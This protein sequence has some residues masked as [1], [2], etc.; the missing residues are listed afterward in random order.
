MVH[1]QRYRR[2]RKTVYV[3][4][5]GNAV[6]G[7]FKLIVGLIGNSS[8][9]VADSLHSI[10]DSLTSVIVW[11]GMKVGT[12]R[13]D[14]EHS[15]GH[16]DAE[17]IAGLFVSI[18]LIFLGFEFAMHSYGKLW[19]PVL[20]PSV[21]TLFAALSSIILKYWMFLYARRVGE[22]IHSSAVVADAY[23][24]KSDYM[25]SVIVL[26]AIAGSIMGYPILD[27]IA[28]IIVSAWIVW[29]GIN[30]CL[31]NIKCLMG[32]VPKEMR[33]EIADAVSS[34][35]GVREFHRLR[36]HRTGPDI[37]ITLHIAIDK[38]KSFRQAHEI[39]KEVE[40]KIK[41]L[42]KNCNVVVHADPE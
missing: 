4:L 3:S 34:V 31:S 25:T 19:A 17:S 9:L 6:L 28:G 16:G 37:S 21:L 36:V 22:E 30:V 39:T 35:K 42:V 2:A 26:F 7:A 38:N 41:S 23:H 14:A 15:Y 24:H 11:V 20:V 5:A 1:E 18:F 33:R 29:I 10:S 32:G 27:P 12:K 13:P 8:A 40:D